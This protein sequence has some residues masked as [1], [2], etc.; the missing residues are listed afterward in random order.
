MR[1]E[2]NELACGIAAE[3]ATGAASTHVSARKLLRQTQLLVSLLA[4]AGG[5]LTLQPSPIPV[6]VLHTYAVV[7]LR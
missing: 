1:G 5:G 7:R 3:V 4:L 6:R 2:S